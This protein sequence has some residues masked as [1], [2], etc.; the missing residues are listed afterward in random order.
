[1]DP[2]HAAVQE[3]ETQRPDPRASVEHEDRAVVQG[4]LDA[5]RVSAVRDGV[6]P[7]C[8][9]RATAAPD[10]HAHAAP[11][12][13]SPEDRDDPY[14]L[15]RVRE[16]WER[17]HGD[18]TL[19]A[20]HAG[21][22]EALVCCAPL[23]EGDPCRPALGWERLGVDGPGR[24]A[25]RPFVKRHLAG[26]GERATDDRLRRLVVE[27]ER[28]LN[29]GDQRRSCKVRRELAGEDENEMLVSSLLHRRKFSTARLPPPLPAPTVTAASR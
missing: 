15:V 24:E 11:A 10:R 5:G 16:E 9:H 29:V 25:R 2:L 8:W 18:L 3:L 7:R 22:P 23:I 14:E 1:M 4:D 17:R 20:V 28:A 13:L 6:G 21:D 19:D 26:L 12:L 27:D